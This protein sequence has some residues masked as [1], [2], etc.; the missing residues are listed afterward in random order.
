MNRQELLARLDTAW[1]AIC[2][3]EGFGDVV[4]ARR[5]WKTCTLAQLNSEWQKTVADWPEFI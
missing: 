2:L 5:Y 3:H 4:G 1:T